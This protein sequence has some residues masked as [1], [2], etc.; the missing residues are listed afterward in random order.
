M[1]RGR[2]GTWLEGSDDWG[3]GKEQHLTRYPQCYLLVQRE[4]KRR[5]D[6]VGVEERGGTYPTSCLPLVIVVHLTA[7]D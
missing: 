7:H 3:K 5:C 1:G 4:E 6:Q 2:W